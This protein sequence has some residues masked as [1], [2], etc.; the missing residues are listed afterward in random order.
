MNWNSLFFFRYIAAVRWIRNN[1]TA[2]YITANETL[3]LNDLFPYVQNDARWWGAAP[4]LVVNNNMHAQG[5][6]S[7][8]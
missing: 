1:M 5:L 8:I 2:V 3:A 6:F 4:N 7:L